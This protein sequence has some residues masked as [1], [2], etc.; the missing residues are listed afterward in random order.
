MEGTREGKTGSRESSRGV[1]AAACMSEDGNGLIL[2][3]G[4]KDREEG[5]L[6][7]LQANLQGLDA[8]GR[9]RHHS[10]QLC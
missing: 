10:L 5:W 8:W 7:T 3:S 6:K 9:G 4:H 1:S 2:D